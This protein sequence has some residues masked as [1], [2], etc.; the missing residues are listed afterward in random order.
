MAADHRSKLLP[1]LAPPESASRNVYGM[2][3]GFATFH[4]Y[5][6]VHDSVQA[7]MEYLQAPEGLEQKLRA[8]LFPSGRSESKTIPREWFPRWGLWAIAASLVA[9]LLFAILVL[10]L[11]R[12]PSA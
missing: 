12:R 9:V 1:Y 6:Q 7:H 5:R 2:G 4:Q 8:Q 3:S 10:Q 11:A